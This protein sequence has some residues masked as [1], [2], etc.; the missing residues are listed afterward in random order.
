MSKIPVGYCDDMCPEKE[1]C[2]RELNRLFAYYESLQFLQGG[3]LKTLDH[4]LAIK[5]YTRSAAAQS[6]PLPHEFRSEIGLTK[7]MRFLFVCVLKTEPSEP[8]QLLRWY[9]FIWDRSRAM[10]KEITQLCAHNTCAV[11]IL[12]RCVRF[13]IYAGYRLSQFEMQKFDQYLNAENLVNSLC[14]LLETYRMLRDQQVV[15]QNEAEFVSYFIIVSLPTVKGGLF[16]VK[17]PRVI[18]ESPAVKFALG[19]YKDFFDIDYIAFFR[20]VQ[21]DATFLQACLLHQFLPLVR[22]NAITVMSVGFRPRLPAV[23]ND[24]LAQ[25]FSFDDSNA[26]QSFMDDLTATFGP[27]VRPPI[28]NDPAL[29]QSFLV[30]HSLVI[31]GGPVDEWVYPLDPPASSFDSSSYYVKDPTFWYYMQKFNV[32]IPGRP[33]IPPEALKRLEAETVPSPPERPASVEEAKEEEKGVVIPVNKSDST[34]PISS[35]APVLFSF[36]VKNVQPPSTLFSMAQ[37]IAQA[38]PNVLFGV[39]PTTPEPITFS[40]A[41]P[42]ASVVPKPT[43]ARLEEEK[44]SLSFPSELHEVQSAKKEEIITTTVAYDEVQY[45]PKRDDSVVSPAADGLI[46]PAGESPKVKSS[47]IK[48]DIVVSTATDELMP[49]VQESPKVKTSPRKEDVVVPTATDELMPLVHESPKVVTSLSGEDTVVS[50]ETDELVI[51]VFA[52]FFMKSLFLRRTV[53]KQPDK[54]REPLA[55]TSEVSCISRREKPYITK[56]ELLRLIRP[57]MLLNVLLSDTVETSLRRIAS[58]VLEVHLLVFNT[59]IERLRH[60]V[61]TNKLRRCFSHWRS[62]ARHKAR[63]KSEIKLPYRR[64]EAPVESMAHQKRLESI[65]ASYRQRTERMFESWTPLNWEPLCQTLVGQPSAMTILIRETTCLQFFLWRCALLLHPEGSKSLIAHWA[66]IQLGLLSCNEIVYYKNCP[67]SRS[68]GVV[69]NYV[70]DRNGTKDVSPDC[71]ILAMDIADDISKMAQELQLLVS[72]CVRPVQLL[73]IV[74]CSGDQ[75]PPEEM[76]ITN[77]LGLADDNYRGKYFS[78]CRLIFSRSDLDFS[79]ERTMLDEEICGFLRH[80]VSNCSYEFLRGYSLI[81]GAFRYFD[82]LFEVPPVYVMGLCFEVL[83]ALLDVTDVFEDVGR[84][85]SPL[86]LQFIGIRQDRLLSRK[87]F[88]ATITSWLP[89][90]RLGKSVFSSGRVF[91]KSLLHDLNCN[92]INENSKWVIISTQ[93]GKRMCDHLQQLRS[94]ALDGTQDIFLV[95]IV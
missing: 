38:T 74:S 92:S 34:V 77:G 28:R 66:L 39:S 18:L 16:K 80:P 44:P 33:L 47:P 50:T 85:V 67:E 14:S 62:W 43:E 73:V 58:T 48:E 54:V 26:A 81:C 84:I 86:V 61:L 40:F 15:C 49:L 60:R 89:T 2:L 64:A 95:Q 65:L 36:A 25:W 82:N 5:Y 8:R 56:Q 71:I 9:D 19:I 76:Y 37:P 87:S 88:W 57:H 72:T 52:K 41:I 91:D 46:T 17:E 22:T 32:E 59:R 24:V 79:E 1:R 29:K 75:P 12:E 27:N 3:D 63:S 51:H 68:I 21:R 45:P 90:G 20:R 11:S 31:N 69:N 42:Q 93:S 94:S 6:S 7:A 55:T 35:A 78:V 70:V 83:C 30:D 13:H 10:R 53:E 23:P 4:C